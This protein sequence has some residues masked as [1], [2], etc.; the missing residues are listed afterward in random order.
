MRLSQRKGELI[1][2]HMNRGAVNSMCVEPLLVPEQDAKRQGMLP[3]L[4]ALCHFDLS[5]QRSISL[6]SGNLKSPSPL[7]AGGTRSGIGH[8]LGWRWP[9]PHYY[10]DIKDGHRFVDRQDW[11]SKTI[12]MRLQEQK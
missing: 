8:W 1:R 9:M 3:M 5:S 4:I 2:D 12:M 6:T 11:T 7:V 10:F